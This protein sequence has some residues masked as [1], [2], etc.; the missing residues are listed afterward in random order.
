MDGILDA[1]GQTILITG[2]AQNIVYHFILMSKGQDI[3]HLKCL[4]KV[5]NIVYHL[6]LNLKKMI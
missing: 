2:K 5:Q 6:D 1:Q 3:V 4:G